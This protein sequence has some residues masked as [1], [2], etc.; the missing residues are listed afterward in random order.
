MAPF[1]IPIVTILIK[2]I[3]ALGTNVGSYARMIYENQ[4]C[5]L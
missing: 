4:I 2:V 5:I 3:F 1:I